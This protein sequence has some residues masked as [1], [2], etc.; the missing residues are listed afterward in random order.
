VN[1]AGGGARAGGQG[2]VA[3]HWGRDFRERAGGFDKGDFGCWEADSG[4]A[5]FPETGA[6]P[7]AACPEKLGSG[8]IL[9]DLSA[10][11]GEAFEDR[12]LVFALRKQVDRGLPPQV[13]EGELGTGRVHPMQPV[14]KRLCRHHC[15]R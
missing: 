7:S 1:G 6:S 13:L 12:W 14:Q 3:R 5:G 4:L 2:A 9:E 15:D 11:L 8:A 10:D